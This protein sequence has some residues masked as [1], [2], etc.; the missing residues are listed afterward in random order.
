MRTVII[1]SLLFTSCIFQ[2]KI[3][4]YHTRQETNTCDVIKF[5]S[6]YAWYSQTNIV[7]PAKFVIVIDGVEYL[8][9]ASDWSN[10]N[11]TGF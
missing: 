8:T 9:N 6:G 11:E 7:I 5:T 10:V 4:K 2:S 1:L 3:E